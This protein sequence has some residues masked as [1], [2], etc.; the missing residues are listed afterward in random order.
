MIPLLRE[1]CNLTGLDVREIDHYVVVSVPSLMFVGETN[2]VSAM[3][4]VESAQKF[5]KPI[6][7][8]KPA[9]IELREFPLRPN[10]QQLVDCCANVIASGRIQ[11]QLLGTSEVHSK[12]GPAAESSQ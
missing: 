4:I 2:G 1:G 9:S 3:E 7:Q 5:R 8:T 10:S 11:V 12:F 6:R